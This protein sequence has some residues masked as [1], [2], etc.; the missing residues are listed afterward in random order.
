MRP[1]QVYGWIS[2]RGRTQ[3]REIV[4]ARSQAEVARLAGVSR[5]GQLFNL[6]DTGNAPEIAQAMAEPGAVFWHPLD[7]RP[8]AWRRAG[9]AVESQV[10]SID[11]P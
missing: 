10:D 1:L 4:A 6:S 5:P 11:S 7:E 8:I 3:A 2:F 9:V